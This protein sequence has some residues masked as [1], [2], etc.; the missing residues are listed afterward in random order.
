MDRAKFLGIVKIYSNHFINAEG[1]RRYS[2]RPFV[3]DVAKRTVSGN[4]NID[5]ISTSHVERQNLTMRTHIERMTR[6]TCAF[7]KK[8]DNLKAAVALH[9][10][11][12]NF[13]KIHKTLRCTP[14]MAAGVT[15]RLWTVADLVQWNPT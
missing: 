7:S 9:F 12:Y 15:S 2:P 10:A 11:Y 1:F 8:L 3:S 6:L 4:P 13:A 5:L 14:A